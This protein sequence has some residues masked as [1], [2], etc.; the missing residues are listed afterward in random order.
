MLLDLEL[1][2]ESR[3]V[4]IDAWWEADEP[5]VWMRTTSGSRARWTITV[6]EAG[7]AFLVRG[8]IGILV[9]RPRAVVERREHAQWLTRPSTSEDHLAEARL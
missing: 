6:E 9:R 3:D 5:E 4:R 2:E 7:I 8:A 1:V